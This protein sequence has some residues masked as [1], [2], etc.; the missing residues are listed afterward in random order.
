[1]MTPNEGN[2]T[3]RQAVRRAL[4]APQSY[5]F[6]ALVSQHP[7]TLAWDWFKSDESPHTAGVLWHDLMKTREPGDSLPR[8]LINHELAKEAQTV[9]KPHGSITYIIERI[10]AQRD[11]EQ[12]LIELTESNGEMIHL[13]AG[14]LDIR[15]IQELTTIL[16]IVKI[17]GTALF[18]WVE[19]YQI[20]HE[21][22]GHH[23]TSLESFV[24]GIRYF[25]FY[26][27]A[28]GGGAKTRVT[29]DMCSRLTSITV[30]MTRDAWGA[31]LDKGDASE[32]EAKAFRDMIRNGITEE[33]IERLQAIDYIIED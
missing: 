9:S 32:A 12:M 23:K 33:R 6:G 22:N 2:S 10:V 7:I 21:N 11:S 20:D 31:T 15:D 26:K 13:L 8:I 29:Y 14:V 28:G 3:F 27:L 1:M 18:E 24:N 30:G 16:K 19:E 4:L 5:T 17:H 25:I